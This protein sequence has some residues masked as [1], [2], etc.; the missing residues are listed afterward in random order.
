MKTLLCIFPIIALLC[1]CSKPAAATPDPRVA[2]LESRISMLESNLNK[3]N[4]KI[5]LLAGDAYDSYVVITNIQAWM[6]TTSD[7][8]DILESKVF[9]K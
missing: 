8:V 7:R 3:A 1:G 2:E 6:H 9:R 4:I 5:N